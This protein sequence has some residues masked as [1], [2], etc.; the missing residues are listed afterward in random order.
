M[1]LHPTF[2][3]ILLRLHVH[4]NQPSRIRPARMPEY[5][6]L[7]PLAGYEKHENSSVG[8]MSLIKPIPPPWSP[9]IGLLEAVPALRPHARG[10]AG[11]QPRPSFK[12]GG[13][14]TVRLP[15]IIMICCTD[16]PTP[17]KF[18][19][20]RNL[21]TA[22]AFLIIIGPNATVFYKKYLSYN[23]LLLVQFQLGL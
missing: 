22:P 9:S 8:F 23:G 2:Q 18:R 13:T 11:A 16:P 14:F 3:A 20:Y 4:D 15:A 12:E 10:N 17:D 6:N 21:V 5:S 7:V 1:H 19:M